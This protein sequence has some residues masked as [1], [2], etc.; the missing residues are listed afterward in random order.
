MRAALAEAHHIPPARRK[1]R[2]RTPLEAAIDGADSAPD[3]AERRLALAKALMPS[4]R[5]PLVRR[6]ALAAMRLAPPGWPKAAALGDLLFQIGEFDAA[7]GVLEACLKHGTADGEALRNLSALHCDL[8]DDRLARDCLMEAARLDPVSGPKRPNPNKPTV[9]RLRSVER[10]HYGIRYDRDSRC[11]VRRLKDGHFSVKD[12]VEHERVNMFVADICGDNLSE[13]ELPPF[14]IVINSVSCGDL[15]PSA[16]RSMDRF[17]ER[18]PA[19]PVINRPLCV[20][21]STRRQN[22]ERLGALDGVL[23]PQSELFHNDA[24][25]VAV[26][27]RLEALGL[28]YPLIVR[29]S[30]THTGDSMWKLDDR[31][32]LLAHLERAPRD[33]ELYAIAFLDCRGREGLYHKRRAFFIDGV[34]YPVA[35]LASDIWQIHSADR[36]RVMADR[37]DLRQEERRYLADPRAFLGTEVFDRLHAIRDLMDLDFFGIDFT[38]DEDGRLVIYEANAAMRHNFDYAG[39]FPYTRAHLERISDAFADML[40]RRV[41]VDA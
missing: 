1:D 2:P 7:H 34:F 23:F 11:Y 22:F 19:T 38:V 37:A 18:Y 14:D 29:R 28:G 5:W 20:L 30:G 27:D 39:A 9:L 6:H 25:P 3:D 24:A 16:L 13:V 10:S 41:A 15:N 35:C 12:L 32:A 40:D 21:E 26:A 36:Y 4:E 17:L 33:V 31:A 8:G